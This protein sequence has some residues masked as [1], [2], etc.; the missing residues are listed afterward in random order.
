MYKLDAVLI[1]SSFSMLL[2]KNLRV[3]YKNNTLKGRDII[4][5]VVITVK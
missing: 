3:H 2:D 5:F 4:I 1:N